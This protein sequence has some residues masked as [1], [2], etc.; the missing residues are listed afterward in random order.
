MR[1][2]IIISGE[3]RS[4]E[5]HLPSL[6]ISE[7][8]TID[9]YLLTYTNTLPFLSNIDCFQS[10]TQ[11]GGFLDFPWKA[12]A[13]Y[14]FETLTFFTSPFP[15]R[16]VYI[17]NVSTYRALC[18]WKSI[19][20]SKSLSDPLESYD[21]ILRWR[22]D[23]VADRC[24]EIPT[25]LNN[26]TIYMPQWHGQFE[27]DNMTLMDQCFFGTPDTMNKIMNVFPCV[28]KDWETIDWIQYSPNGE[29]L[30]KYTIDKQ[31]LSIVR[32]EVHLSLRRPYGFVMF[33]YLT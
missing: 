26:N 1:I 29:G 15:R 24:I 21:C 22:P 19:Y 31:N 33:E 28:T 2:A 23:L 12:V 27:L 20:D 6:S 17:G 13:F 14:P 10:L 3:I 8:T 9:Y 5:V 32:W 7:N 18:M 4:N 16:G 25:T 11:L 30:M